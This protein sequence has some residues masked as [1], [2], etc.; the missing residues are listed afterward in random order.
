MNQ[1]LKTFL[2]NEAGVNSLWYIASP[3]SSDDPSI[4]AQRVAD[5][6]KVVVQ[7]TTKYPDVSPFSPVLYTA[8]LQEK[9]LA[10]GPPRGWYAFDF[11]FLRNADRLLVLKLDGWESSIGI[12][13]E[14]AFAEARG[15]PIYYYT[16][17]ELL[18]DEDVP[19]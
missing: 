12:A 15:L 3:Y 2:T 5:V 19:F 14:V 9:G 11:A 10:S 6:E 8:N 17:E 16:L 18:S 4:V 1:E 13:L 7:I